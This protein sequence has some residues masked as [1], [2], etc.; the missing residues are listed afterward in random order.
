MKSDSTFCAMVCEMFLDNV[1]TS[2]VLGALCADEIVG[3]ATAGVEISAADFNGESSCD[4]ADDGGGKSLSST[5]P[6]KTLRAPW[7]V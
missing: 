7:M 2:M 1:G 5:L 6:V 4:G 3:A